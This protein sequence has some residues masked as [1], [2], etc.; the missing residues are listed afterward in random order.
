MTVR[1]PYRAEPV[2][3]GPY[4]RAEQRRDRR[5]QAVRQIGKLALLTFGIFIIGIVV[6]NWSA[7]RAKLPTYYPSCAWARSAGAA[8]IRRGSPGYR[9]QLDADDDGVACEPY[10]GG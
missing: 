4:W 3:L 5:R 6:T 7:L 1:K 2:K 9:S 8:P 10:R